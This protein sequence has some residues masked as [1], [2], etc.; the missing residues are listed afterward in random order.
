MGKEGPI[1]SNLVVVEVGAT[2]TGTNKNENS[3]RGKTRL[4]S[5]ELQFQEGSIQATWRWSPH[6]ATLRA[7]DTCYGAGARGLKEPRCFIS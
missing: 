2:V 3:E 1:P 7:K 5:V 6:I 4:C